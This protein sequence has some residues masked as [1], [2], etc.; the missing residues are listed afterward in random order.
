[1]K[2]VILEIEGEVEVKLS[3][4]FPEDF[5]VLEYLEGGIKSVYYI[6]KAWV[7][8]MKEVDNVSG[9]SSTTTEE[10]EQKVN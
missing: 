2:R 6:K 4:V 5:V 7:R 9:Q 8:E 3:D 10:T 1:M